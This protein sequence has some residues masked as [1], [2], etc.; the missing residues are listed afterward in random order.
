MH[1]QSVTCVLCAPP[2]CEIAEG[3]RYLESVCCENKKCPTD[4]MLWHTL[5]CEDWHEAVT[6]SH[7]DNVFKDK[8]GP[9]LHS[10]SD[11][12]ANPETLLYWRRLHA[13]VMLP[14]LQTFWR[15]V[16]VAYSDCK[17][18]LASFYLYEDTQ[19]LQVHVTYTACGDAPCFVLGAFQDRA[20]ALTLV[21]SLTEARELAQI[22]T[23]Q[24]AGGHVK[25][26]TAEMEKVMKMKMR[27]VGM[28]AKANHPFPSC[29]F[30]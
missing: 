1:D 20:S 8:D 11:D 9:E 6:R 29:R 21:A 28:N 14:L 22:Q 24:T 23:L 12:W 18:S 16:L 26:K 5:W 17:V 3:I 25:T 7:G 13:R 30:Q 10:L 19:T 15:T 27:K 4:R 2:T